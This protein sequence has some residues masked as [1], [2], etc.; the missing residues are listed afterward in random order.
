MT[1][2]YSFNVCL[3]FVR[4]ERD[5]GTTSAWNWLLIILYYVQTS[6]IRRQTSFVLTI[7]KK[8]DVLGFCSITT[9]DLHTSTLTGK[10]ME[11]RQ[12]TESP[13]KKEK[14]EDCCSLS[15]FLYLC[16]LN[17]IKWFRISVTEWCFYTF[18]H[19]MQ[20]NMD[21]SRWWFSL[22]ETGVQSEVELKACPQ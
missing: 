3:S 22:R 18:L 15:C 2:V 11:K 19:K 21:T 7:R 1:L 13:K 10:E 20:S 9:P 8:S 6:G 14:D 17:Q 16:L 12:R 4:C 5:L